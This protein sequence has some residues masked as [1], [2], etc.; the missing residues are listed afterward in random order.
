M[1]MLRCELNI[2]TIFPPVLYNFLCQFAYE[3]KCSV[4]G[5][6]IYLLKLHI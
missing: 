6:P 2:G 1:Q 5:T 4:E 3:P